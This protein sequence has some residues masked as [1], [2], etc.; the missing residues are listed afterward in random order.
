MLGIW[1]AIKVS[2]FFYVHTQIAQ[3]FSDFLHAISMTYEMIHDSWRATK[4]FILFYV[5]TKIAHP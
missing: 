1:R 4:V 2:Y 5:H 3:P